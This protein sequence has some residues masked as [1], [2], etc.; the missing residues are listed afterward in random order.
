MQK[1]IAWLNNMHILRV[2]YLFIF[3]YTQPN[4]Y[5]YP[6]PYMDKEK[7]NLFVKLSQQDLPLIWSWAKPRPTCHI[8][9]QISTP[10]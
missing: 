3:G 8:L 2:T 4:I 9:A 5:T 7:C 6:Y 10:N 1:I